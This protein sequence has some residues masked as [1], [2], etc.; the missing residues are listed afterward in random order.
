MNEWKEYFD[1]FMT[2]LEEECVYEPKAV[3]AT[4]A[5]PVC[6]EILPEEALKYIEA[7]RKAAYEQGYSEGYERGVEETK[8]EIKGKLGL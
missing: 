8:S 4:Q 3:P 7:V 6:T 2:E 1:K 5:T